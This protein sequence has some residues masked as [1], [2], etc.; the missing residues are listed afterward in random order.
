MSNLPFTHPHVFLSLLYNSSQFVCLFPET[1]FKIYIFFDI[2][3]LSVGGNSLRQHANICFFSTKENKTWVW[4]D[5]VNDHRIVGFVPLPGVLQL[6]HKHKV[7]VVM[8][9]A[10]TSSFALHLG[11]NPVI[12]IQTD[13]THTRLKGQWGQIVTVMTG[14]V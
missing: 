11:D 5:K 14:N 3:V 10:F 8:H 1:F 6:P 13:S 7:T 12:I 9:F 4:N 2:V